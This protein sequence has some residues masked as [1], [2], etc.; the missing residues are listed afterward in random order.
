MSKH[1]SVRWTNSITE[2]TF[3]GASWQGSPLVLYGLN[4]AVGIIMQLGNFHI[5]QVGFS[6]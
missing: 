1:Y 5:A 2:R 4:A 3:S 6:A